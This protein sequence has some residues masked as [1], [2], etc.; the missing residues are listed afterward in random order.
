L[1]L[2]FIYLC[3]ILRLDLVVASPL[4]A[5][6]IKGSLLLLILM[7]I[8]GSFFY[9]RLYI[10][11]PSIINHFEQEAF[12]SNYQVF[13]NAISYAHLYFQTNKKQDCKIDCWVKGTIG[14][15]FNS[16]GYPV[17]TRYSQQNAP[18]D[19]LISEITSNDTDCAQ[20]WVFLMGP[21]QNNI[22]TKQGHYKAEFRSN[23]KSC[24]YRS[25]II[26]NKSIIYRA[27]RG[28]VQLL[29]PTTNKD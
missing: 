26:T 16:F 12:Q 8:L 18:F 4:T 29:A 28:T 1:R 25:K 24:I 15:D 3:G 9:H 5:S 2:G 13:K 21:L 7:L 27:D 10:R 22:N 14:L 20:V 6:G 11:N 23:N 19:P 17:S